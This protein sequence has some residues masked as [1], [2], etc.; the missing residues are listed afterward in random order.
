MKMMCLKEKISNPIHP[1]G[2]IL[3]RFC[4]PQANQ[5]C[6]SDNSLMFFFF[7]ND[8]M[9]PQYYHLLASLRNPHCVRSI[10]LVTPHVVFV[11]DYYFPRLLQPKTSLGVLFIFYINIKPWLPPRPFERGRWAPWW[12]CPWGAQPA[13]PDSGVVELRLLKQIRFL[14]LTEDLTGL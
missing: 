1:L 10:A 9:N 11:C 5:L 6:S 8:N 2:E 3:A 14:T 4:G 12:G 13:G 7:F